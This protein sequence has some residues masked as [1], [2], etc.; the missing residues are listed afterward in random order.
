MLEVAQP[1]VDQ[2]GDAD[3]VRA[4]EVVVLDQ[5]HRQAAAGG[6][7]RDAGA[8]DAAADDQQVAG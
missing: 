8:V 5:Q 3:E 4:G 2:L 1:A 7:A 6:V